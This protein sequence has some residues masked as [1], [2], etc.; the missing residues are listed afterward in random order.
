MST[1]TS[2][3]HPRTSSPD[4]GTAPTERGTGRTRDADNTRRLLLQAARRRFARDGYT[5]TTVREI[6]ADAGVN[7]SLINRYF[8]SKEG[9]F[10]ACLRRVVADLDPAVDVPAD[11]EVRTVEQILETILSQL[12]VLSTDDHPLH[13]LL[14]LRSSG[15][16]RADQIRRD[17]LKSFAEGMAVAAGWEQGRDD[18]PELLLRAQVALSVALGIVLLRSSTGLEPLSSATADELRAPLGATLHALL[19]PDVGA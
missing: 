17:T 1:T 14:L 8:S 11:T 12:T 3:A 2:T 7:V 15:D 10:E 18:G 16:E 19:S 4:P 9:L 5:G 6:A 13:L